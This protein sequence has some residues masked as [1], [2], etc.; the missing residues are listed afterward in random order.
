MTNKILLLCHPRS[1]S[2]H[3]CNM[4]NT[5]IKFKF[6]LGISG[7]NP[8]I[9]PQEILNFTNYKKQIQHEDDAKNHL[10]KTTG[11]LPGHVVSH[12]TV[13]DIFTKHIQNNHEYIF[14]YFPLIMEKTIDVDTMI[15]ICK[16][17]NIKVVSLRRR[18][19]LNGLISHLISKSTGIW[20]MRYD[21]YQ[22][23]DLKTV[24]ACS[25]VIKDFIGYY[26]RYQQIILKFNE[27][28]Q[29]HNMIDYEDLKFSS[30]DLY[31]I[32]E[33]CN[34]EIVNRIP[35]ILKQMT[36]SHDKHQL[37][38]QNQDIRNEIMSGL[39]NSGLDLNIIW[40]FKE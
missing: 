1:G 20:N 17:H 33:N 30:E 22:N 35:T 10:F 16:E 18:N 19:I 4:F 37:F 12:S 34:T 11:L 14:K 40:R 25:T 24:T 13:A 8:I 3:I 39:A 28:Y 21:D 9:M 27:N 5:Y 23:V 38:L 7:E 29:I 26:E 31:D 6:N 32:L 36:T 15:E 2:T